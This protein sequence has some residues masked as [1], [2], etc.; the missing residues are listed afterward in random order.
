MRL[1]PYTSLSVD[2]CVDCK[3]N[4]LLFNGQY[5]HEGRVLSRIG[6]V[7]K[8]A[9][10]HGLDGGGGTCEDNLQYRQVLGQLDVSDTRTELVLFRTL[11]GDQ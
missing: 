11:V 6:E 4:V 1:I 8:T 5:Y 3:K 2:D 10:E 9:T 7:K